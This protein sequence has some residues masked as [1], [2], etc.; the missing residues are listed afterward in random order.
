MSSK[1]LIEFLS[2]DC[3]T[4]NHNNCHG[5]WSGFG[6]KIICRCSCNHGNTEKGGQQR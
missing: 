1:S 2:K 5:E 3:Q 4:D 6:F